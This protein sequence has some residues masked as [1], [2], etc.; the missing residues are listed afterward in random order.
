M[1]T[2]MHR[3]RRQ[4]FS[5]FASESSRDRRPSWVVVGECETGAK[6]YE[7]QVRRMAS[8]IYSMIMSVDGYT[9]D[10][11]GEFGWGRSR[12]TRRFTPSSTSSGPHSAPTSTERRMYETMVY[13]E[14]AHTV[15][16]QPPFVLDFVRQWQSADKIVY[17]RS[18]AEPRSGHPDRAELRYRRGPEAKGKRAA[19]PDG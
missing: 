13:W 4:E 15:P 17:S 7:R 5:G 2:I 10:E 8:L 18:L 1:Y 12:R 14:T 19:R 16:D 9:E 6:G 11:H 3:T